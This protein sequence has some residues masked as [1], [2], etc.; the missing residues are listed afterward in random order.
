LPL[1]REASPEASVRKEVFAEVNFHAAEEPQ[2]CVRTYRWK[3]IRR[4]PIGGAP[5]ELYDVVLD[6]NERN[7]LALSAA[8][9]AIKSMLRAQ[10]DRWMRDTADPLADLVLPLPPT[11]VLNGPNDRSPKLPATTG[12]RPTN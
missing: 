5:E 11:S 2:R 3:Y 8:H 9:A 10:L 7:N 12:S 4:F 6:P 1:V